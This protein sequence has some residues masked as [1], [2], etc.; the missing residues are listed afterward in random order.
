MGLGAF[1]VWPDTRLRRKKM[2]RWCA[3]CGITR[4]L[5]HALLYGKFSPNSKCWIAVWARRPRPRGRHL[6]A[7]GGHDCCGSHS[8]GNASV[9]LSVVSVL[10]SCKESVKD[11][12]DYRL[13]PWSSCGRPDG[14]WSV[15]KDSSDEAGSLSALMFSD[16]LCHGDSADEPGDSAPSEGTNAEP[17]PS[18]SS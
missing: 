4:R 6:H 11:Q 8:R 13:R 9:L 5:M 16:P 7:N 14:V 18:S 12:C 17:A 15:S 2:S 10:V 1:P 3:R